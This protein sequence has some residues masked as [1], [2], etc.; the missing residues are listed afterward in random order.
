M[1]KSYQWWFQFHITYTKQT[2]GIISATESLSWILTYA[3]RHRNGKRGS[4]Y[5]LRIYLGVSHWD[6]HWGITT[7]KLQYGTFKFTPAACLR[8][9]QTW[10]QWQWWWRACVN[11]SEVGRR[12]AKDTPC[13][14]TQQRGVLWIDDTL[15]SSDEKA[16]SRLVPKRMQKTKRNPSSNETEILQGAVSGASRHTSQQEREDVQVQ[17]TGRT[18]IARVD[19]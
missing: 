8:E 15:L 9:K 14:H 10:Y 2:S 16:W 6:S 19:L 13:L 1:S 4:T 18:C 11:E 5:L 17:A 7:S 3:V 12:D